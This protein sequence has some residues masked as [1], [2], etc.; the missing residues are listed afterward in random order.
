MKTSSL[1]NCSYAS[2]DRCNWMM[3]YSAAFS[4]TDL[5]VMFPLVE[6]ECSVG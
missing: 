4:M 2:L 1:Q 6:N 3:S 5:T